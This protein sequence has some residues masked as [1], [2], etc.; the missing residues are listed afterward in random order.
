LNRNDRAIGGSL[1]PSGQIEKDLRRAGTAKTAV[2]AA[3]SKCAIRNHDKT[4]NERLVEAR[5]VSI[6]A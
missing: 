2:P 4:R 5:D 3:F 1:R 6:A